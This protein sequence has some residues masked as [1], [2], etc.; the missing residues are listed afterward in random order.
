MAAGSRLSLV[1]GRLAVV[2]EAIR[3]WAVPI[4]VGLILIVAA[5]LKTHQLATEELREQTFLTSRTFLTLLVL[6]E[7]ALTVGLLSGLA[8]GLLRWLAIVT[9]AVF[10]EVSLYQGVMKYG[11]CGC[12][13]KVHVSPWVMLAVDSLVLIALVLWKPPTPTGRP[14]WDPWRLGLAAAFYAWLVF[15]LLMHIVYYAPTGI[16]YSLRNDERLRVFVTFDYKEP[17]TPEHLLTT[18][19]QATGLHVSLHPRLELDPQRVGPLQA[20]NIPVWSVME[21]LALKQ[22]TAARWDR[23]PGG[24]ELRPA[25]PLGH[26]AVPWLLSAL[27]AAATVV[28]YLVVRRKQSAV[29]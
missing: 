17:P 27:G 13:G 15:P 7:T 16:M 25:A 3:V 26:G 5:G 12:L 20:K 4:A 14:L 21:S 11:G 23:V 29:S 18:L 1:Q 10:F 19:Q 2:L 28:M 9:F 6:Y 24:Y 8:P 22:R